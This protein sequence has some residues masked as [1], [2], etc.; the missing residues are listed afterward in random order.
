MAG[1]TA[2]AMGPGLVMRF[3]GWIWAS[4]EMWKVGKWILAE[5]EFRKQRVAYEDGS[6]EF[7]GECCK[8]QAAA[9]GS[10]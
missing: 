10:G 4:G 8:G 2:V 6:W 9:E 1:E 5:G 7:A 3:V